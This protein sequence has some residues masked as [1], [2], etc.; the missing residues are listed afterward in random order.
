MTVLFHC[1]KESYVPH[2]IPQMLER[3]LEKREKTENLLSEL[4][5]GYAR[6]CDFKNQG[7][8]ANM[9][10]REYKHNK[11]LIWGAVSVIMQGVTSP[12]LAKKVFYPLG[13]GMLEKALADRKHT[14]PEVH[15]YFTILWHCEMYDKAIGYIQTLHGDD[16]DK[17]DGTITQLE[18]DQMLL[19]ALEA[20]ELCDGLFALANRMIR[21][22]GFENFA[23][24]KAL[25]GL[26]DK[27]IARNETEKFRVF[28][29]E[30]A[31]LVVLAQEAPEGSSLTQHHKHTLSM[32]I[33]TRIVRSGCCKI[34]DLKSFT[35]NFQTFVEHMKAII[36]M[37][38]NRP[39]CF[40]E[41]SQSFSMLRGKDKIE[42]LD[43]LD[44][45]FGHRIDELMKQDTI[46]YEYVIRE[47]FR[48]GFGDYEEDDSKTKREYALK[49]VQLLLR[50]SSDTRNIEDFAKHI[51]III[52]NIMWE[53]YID[54]NSKD[55]LYEASVMLESIYDRYPNVYVAGLLLA[56]IYD[57]IGN[58]QRIM[59]LHNELGIKFIQR[60]SLGYLT[61]T[62]AV[63]F[64]RFKESI[65]YFTSIT[66]Q[67]D[68]N[69][70]ETCESIVTS[71]KVTGLD[72]VPQLVSYLETCRNSL[73]ARGADVMNQT[74]SACFAVDSLNMVLVTLYGD[75]ERIEWSRVTDTR[76]FIAI[77]CFCIS[78]EI[79]T[80]HVKDITFSEMVDYFRLYHLLGKLI[81]LTGTMELDKLT[82][83]GNYAALRSH[84]DYCKSIY[85]QSRSARFLQGFGAPALVP[86]VQH[87]FMRPIFTL[88]DVCAEMMNF[89]ANIDEVKLSDLLDIATKVIVKPDFLEHLDQCDLDCE[90]A[91]FLVNCSH[92]MLLM[93]LNAILLKFLEARAQML[94]AM[95]KSD[96]QT[97][98]EELDALFKE[99]AQ[100]SEKSNG[101]STSSSTA[102]GKKNKKQNTKTYE[103]MTPQEK[104]PEAFRIA[105][106][107]LNEVVSEFETRMRTKLKVM[108]Q[109]DSF[110]PTD[111]L[112]F[113]A[114][115][116]DA[117]VRKVDQ[118]LFESYCRSLGELILCSVRIQLFFRYQDFSL[119]SMHFDGDITERN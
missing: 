31:K 79:E 98:T 7:R 10:F 115:N 77:Q 96:D 111:S 83:D 8:V 16:D 90:P 103:E 78:D 21:Q 61:F 37:T 14:R 18:C 71:N 19:N 1:F 101:T 70:R 63:K 41:V 49:L 48:V 89:Q 4:Y 86:L 110:C 108:E 50:Q 25:F 92:A 15:L 9:L 12:A 95:F 2:R 82:F 62:S 39:Y 32:L 75:D 13:L 38:Y 88:F 53:V 69:E 54:T 35:P 119:M 57:V 33:L 42:L 85:H 45:T 46:D 51:A 67:F 113:K 72:K 47:L 11:Y 76:D 93:T 55:A 43:F 34:A 74:L 24:W 112:D 60:E 22:T 105:Y 94:V 97:K 100:I 5:Y 29:D 17:V 68:Q 118:S 40:N 26:M 66:T 102:K 3:V 58:I 52:G 56:R 44:V 116:L 104:I 81:G 65:F 114:A 64:G 59:M 20:S 6:V 107:K 30:C 28:L 109:T 106:G 87:K 73:F 23:P 99:A 84:Y 27:F 91:E 36:T 80:V 117:A